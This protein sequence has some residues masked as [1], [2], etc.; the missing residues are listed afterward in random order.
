MKKRYRMPVV[1][2]VDAPNLTVAQLIATQFKVVVNREI[3]TASVET[4]TAL[5]T[6]TRELRLTVTWGK[7]EMVP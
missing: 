3:E 2:E 4:K 6:L 5:A 1:F 7:V